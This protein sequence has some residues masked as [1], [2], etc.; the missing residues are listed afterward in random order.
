MDVPG[1]SGHDMSNMKDMPMGGDKDSDASAHVMHSMEG[2]MDMGSHMKMTAR[3][4]PRPVIL[5]APTRS[6]KKGERLQKSIR[7]TTP[8]WPRDSRF[9]IPKFR[10]RCITSRTTGTPSKQLSDSIQ[11][12]PRPCS[13][14]NTATTTSW[15]A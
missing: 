10:R 9:S 8:L 11:S 2:H 12:I 5:H 7:I 14:K 1:M 3:A 4:S 13:T 15:S 6:Q